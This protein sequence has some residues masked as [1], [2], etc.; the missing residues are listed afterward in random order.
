MRSGRQ[1]RRFRSLSSESQRSLFHPLIFQ[2]LPRVM[3]L[4]TTR[5]H[6]PHSHATSRAGETGTWK[7][8]ERL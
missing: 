1:L 8:L 4:I 7:G 5:S 2:M 6:V 3:M